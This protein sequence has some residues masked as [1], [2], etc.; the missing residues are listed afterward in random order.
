MTVVYGPAIGS[1]IERKTGGSYDPRAVSIG[2]V[3]RK[4][5]HAGILYEC[6]NGATVMAHM[7]AEGFLTREFLWANADYAFR[8]LKLKKIVAP[9]SSKNTRM[10]DMA[11]KMGFTYEAMIADGHPEG[12]LV[13]MTLAAKDCRFSGEKYGKTQT[14]RNA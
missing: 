6:W 1:W 4:G 13:L 11:A 2:L 3:S 8:Q 14:T 9:I 7:A 12:D 10:L 5:I